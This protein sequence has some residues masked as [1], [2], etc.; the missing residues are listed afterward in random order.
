MLHSIPRLDLEAFAF[1]GGT[2]S[3][4]PAKDHLMR[5][6]TVS[7]WSVSSDFFCM[8]RLSTVK[9][10]VRRKGEIFPERVQEDYR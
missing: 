9:G 7:I 1:T 2:A 8:L 6:G 4:L 3:T 5:T 10:P